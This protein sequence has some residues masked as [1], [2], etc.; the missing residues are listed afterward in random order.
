[1]AGRAIIREMEKDT[2]QKVYLFNGEKFESAANP[3]NKYSTVRKKLSMQKLGPGYS[4]GK[5]VAELTG[6]KIGLV[7]NAR[8]G[9]KIEWWEKGYDGPNDYNLYENAIKQ[10]KKAEKYGTLKGILWLQGYANKSNTED[11]MSLLKKFVNDLR[12][13][14]DSDVYFI[15][16][17]L[18]KWQSSTSKI[19]G[20]IDKIPDEINNADYVSSDGLQPLHDDSTNPHF[21][22]K[23]Q[24][25]LGQQYAVK[26]LE[27]IYHISLCR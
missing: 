9:T 12:Q 11:Y 23:S 1:M 20:I 10:L 15:A 5:E 18:G 13:D 2:L 21:N 7:V 16:G 25:I 26:V 17:E 27:H 4:F 3:L 14:I 8:G 19:N 24:L 22:T 6:R